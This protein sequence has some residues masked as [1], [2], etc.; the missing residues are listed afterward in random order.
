MPPKTRQD[1]G[2][3]LKGLLVRNRTINSSDTVEGARQLKVFQGWQAERLRSTYADF[4]SEPGY[5]P[6]VNFFLDDLYGP[7]DFSQRDRDVERIYPG[8]VRVLPERL[9]GTLA[10]AV[11]LNVLSAELDR[12]M[13]DALRKR[14]VAPEDLTEGSFQQAYVDVGRF[15]DRKRQLALVDRLG[16]DLQGAVRQRVLAAALRAARLP[17]RIAGLQELQQF[18]ERGLDAFLAMPDANRFVAAVVS[19]ESEFLAAREAATA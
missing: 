7:H 14:S 5:R 12:D 10:D 6:A 11:E 15:N 13:V 19:R 8:L 4:A 16:A 1:A 9:L 2:V 17:A 3:R 18:L